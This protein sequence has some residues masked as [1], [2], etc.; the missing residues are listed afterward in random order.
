MKRQ[1]GFTL[2]E[3]MIVVAIIGILAA[4]AIPAY[5]DYT[6]RTQVTEGLN[7]ASEIKVAAGDFWSARGR[8][9]NGDAAASIGIAAVPA[10]I[11]GNYVTQIDVDTNSTDNVA[12]AGFSIDIEYGNRAN[13][14]IDGLVLTLRATSNAAGALVWVCGNA[15]APQGTAAPVG[16]NSTDLENKYMPADCRP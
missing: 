5:Q 3:L 13:N 15:N 11:S 10:S 1:S 12:D 4:I 14:K 6:I 9:P 7:L 16:A 2:I 8:T